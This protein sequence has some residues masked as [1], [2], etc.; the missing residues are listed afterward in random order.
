MSQHQGRPVAERIGY[1]YGWLIGQFVFLGALTIAGPSGRALLGRIAVPWPLALDILGGIAVSVLGFV[2]AGQA[3]RTL[4]DSLRVAPSP[5]D[6]AELVEDGWY[7]RVRHPLYLAAL[8]I[9]TGWM[10]VWM[11]AATFIIGLA[12]GGFFGFK[13]RHEERLLR[14]T[15]PGYRAYSSRVRSR[16]VPRIW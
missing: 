11:N 15:Y 6:D 3:R 10:L 16:I 4:G 7:G 9:G 12:T 1:D 2:I 14:E 13:I 5:L 8:L